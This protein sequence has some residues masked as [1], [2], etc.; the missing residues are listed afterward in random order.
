[1][2]QKTWIAAACVGDSLYVRVQGDDLRR[3]IGAGKPE[4]M[5]VEM[6]EP[7]LRDDAVMPVVFA[8]RDALRLATV[9]AVPPATLTPLPDIDPRI[10]LLGLDGL[11]QTRPADI[12]GAESAQVAGFV[13]AYPEWDGVL[14][15]TG[16]H[17]KWV[18]ISAG[19][20]VS[21]QSFMTGEL[22]AVLAEHSV[23]RRALEGGGW[24]DAAFTEALSDAMSRP[25][26]VAGQLFS[27]HAAGLLAGHDPATA[28]ARLSGMLTGMEMAAARP[29]WLG[30]DVAVIGEGAQAARYE[31]AL[32][33]QGVPVEVHDAA[34]LAFRGLE[35]A[36]DA[37]GER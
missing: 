35:Q 13:A 15:L 4:Q 2:Q 21:F 27:L 6:L 29:Y 19:E 34:S 23:L 20:V 33:A 3:E 26:R 7:Y 25:E 9:P 11:A 37:Q 10:V 36:H 28:R 30:R 32:R 14:C 12:L 17:S 1:M 31:A 8:G 22:F 5:L 24:D 18:H 16:P